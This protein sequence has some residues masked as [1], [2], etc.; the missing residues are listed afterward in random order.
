MLLRS[1]EP[2]FVDRRAVDVKSRGIAVVKVESDGD[3]VGDAAGTAGVLR[4]VA[5]P[6]SHAAQGRRRC[7]LDGEREAV[8]IGVNE[9]EAELG[10]ELGHAQRRCWKRRWPLRRYGRP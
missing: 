7:P 5:E 6:A 3:A 1:M 8:R 10:G 9:L 2:P 4:P